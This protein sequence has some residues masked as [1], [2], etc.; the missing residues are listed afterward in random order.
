MERYAASVS[1]GHTRQFAMVSGTVE[2][3]WGGRKTV[4]LID[5]GSELNL[6][7]KSIYDDSGLDI[8]E[9]GSRW[10]LRGIGGTPIALLGCVRD[11]P[12]QLAGK[13]FDHHFFVSSVARGVHDGILGQPWL[14]FFSAQ[15]DYARDGT[16]LLR[17]YPS[18]SRDGASVTVEICKANHPRNADRLVLT[19]SVEE[20]ADGQDFQ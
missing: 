3:V 13:N 8:D 4:L 9:D 14:S 7:C 6:I 19:A 20:V 16:T 15:F 2:C 10:S 12:V 5:S 17:A 11:A 18:G 1:F